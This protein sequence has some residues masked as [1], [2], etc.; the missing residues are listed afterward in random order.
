[1][2]KLSVEDLAKI[3]DRGRK[4]TLLREG[5]CRA[6]ITVHMG[7]CGIAAGARPVMSA[8]MA[9][10]D[11]RG[12]Q[13]VI[14]DITDCAGLCDL[15][16]MMTVEIGDEAPVEYGGL[17]PEKAVRVLDDHVMGGNVVREFVALRGREKDS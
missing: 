7:T 10:L 14:L 2:P 3:R 11:K 16:P 5:L 17:T 6:R 15:E 9:E 12:I 1:M 13:D 8:L 4:T